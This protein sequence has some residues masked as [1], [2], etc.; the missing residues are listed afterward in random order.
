MS[1]VESPSEAGS[2]PAQDA[3]QE[4]SEIM[5]LIEPLVRLIKKILS[6]PGDPSSAEQKAIN[7]ARDGVAA[8]VSQAEGISMPRAI[9]EVNAILKPI[10]QKLAARATVASTPAP[11]GQQAAMPAPAMG[12]MPA[13]Q[14]DNALASMAMQS[15]MGR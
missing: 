4:N 7:D 2:E 12:S 11:V 13:A 15:R 1:I 6:K 10:I 8:R 9:N 14:D 5:P 3:G